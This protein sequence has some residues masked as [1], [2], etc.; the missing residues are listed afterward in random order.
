MKLLIVLFIPIIT[1]GQYVFTYQDTLFGKIN[2]ERSWWNV[3]RYDIT[4]QPTISTQ[5]IQGKVTAKFTVVETSSTMQIDLQH[6]LKIDS[7]F[8]PQSFVTFTREGNAYHLHFK[9]QLHLKDTGSITI[10]YSGSPVQAKNPP[11]EGGWIWTKDQK[12]RPWI[13]VAS[14]HEGAS[15][16]FPCKDHWSDEP[17]NGA[18]LTMIV[19]DTLVAVSNGTRGTNRKVANGLS[20]TTWE[21]NSPINNYSIVPYIGKYVHW[22][23]NFKGEKG[24][25]ACDYWVLDYELEIAQKQF[26]QVPQLL[27][28][29]EHWFGPYPF[30]NDGYKVVQSPYLGMEHQSAIAYGNKFE[31]GYLGTDLSQTGWGLKWDFILVHE[32]AHEWFGNSI[33]AK[34]IADMWIHEAFTNY[35]ETIYTQCQSGEKAGNEYEIGLRKLIKNDRP[36]IGEYD[37]HSKGSDDMYYK[38]SNLVHMIRQLLGNDEEFRKLLRGLTTTFYQQTVTTNEIEKYVS[39]F[40]KIDL[41]TLFDQYLRT[42]KIPVLEYKIIDNQVSIRWSNCVPGFD[43]NLKLANGN[44]IKPSETWKNIPLQLL[45]NNELKIDANFYVDVKRVD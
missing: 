15:C 35:A 40:T 9:N 17:E 22:N 12:N 27:K 42:T 2:T 20:S 8:S 44:W 16:W 6:P 31:N 30:Y 37:V 23:E 28:C 24:N 39:N 21:V 4:I 36:I 34:D 43:L 11:W 7:I 41:S 33:T 19:P 14:Q 1:F 29:F 25:L 5:T 13:T 45:E 38:G 26:K 3:V 32:S 18:S 10:Y